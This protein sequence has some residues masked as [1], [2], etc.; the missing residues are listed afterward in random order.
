[1]TD[2][3]QLLETF[4]PDAQSK[5][6]N[7]LFEDPAVQPAV[8]A[9]VHALLEESIPSRVRAI[10]KEMAR[11]TKHLDTGENFKLARMY[12]IDDHPEAVAPFLHD[13]AQLARLPC[14][15]ATKAAFNLLLSV[16]E[17]SIPSIENEWKEPGGREPFDRA[18]DAML[19]KLATRRRE[20]EG[21]TFEY[22]GTLKELKKTAAE[23]KEDFESE[24]WFPKTIALMESWST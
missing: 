2:P 16:A 5:L 20:E 23:M 7:K 13:V 4:T 21:D 24:S 14:R 9:A 6:L 22:A 12:S 18:A 1:M 8:V 19:F 15:G 17:E 11:A 3:K 10:E